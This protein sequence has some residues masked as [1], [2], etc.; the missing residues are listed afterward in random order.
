MII[1]TRSLLCRHQFPGLFQQRDSALHYLHRN[2]HLVLILSLALVSNVRGIGLLDV[3][4]ARSC[5][6]LLSYFTRLVKRL[7]LS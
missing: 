4:S 7:V 1:H 6:K 5:R 2:V 3:R